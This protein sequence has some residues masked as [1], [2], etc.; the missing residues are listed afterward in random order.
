[1][2]ITINPQVKRKREG[3]F[4][5]EVGLKGSRDGS[6]K[7]SMKS[8]YDRINPNVITTGGTP[9]PSLSKTLI[10][11]CS[12]AALYVKDTKPWT[13]CSNLDSSLLWW[14]EQLL[15]VLELC[16]ALGTCRHHISDWRCAGIPEE[17]REVEPCMAA[18]PKKESKG[19]VLEVYPYPTTPS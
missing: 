5:V 19:P 10:A 11:S 17:P 4:S 1:M 8:M 12:P 7:G 13:S 16:A 18:P 9:P 3:G 14:C 15:S 6:F 2:Q